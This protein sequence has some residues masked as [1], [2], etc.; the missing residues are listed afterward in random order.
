MRTTAVCYAQLKSQIER[1]V[2]KN[3]EN[4]IE[5]LE[6]KNFCQTKKRKI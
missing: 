4:Q 5:V 2:I 3:A 6:Y 1:D